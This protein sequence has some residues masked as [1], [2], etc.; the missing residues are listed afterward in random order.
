MNNNTLSL[1]LLHSH[2]LHGLPA[3]CNRGKESNRN[4]DLGDEKQHKIQSVYNKSAIFVGIKRLRVGLVFFF[5]LLPLLRVHGRLFLTPCGAFEF[6][7]LGN[8][9]G[10]SL[11]V[12]TSCVRSP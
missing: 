7:G 1:G 11:G 12:A 10:V 2:L 6:F 8:C 4:N 3:S 9:F 5:Y